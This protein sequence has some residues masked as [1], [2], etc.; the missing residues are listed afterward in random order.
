MWKKVVEIQTQ[1]HNRETCLLCLTA[2]PYNNDT[3]TGSTRKS[4]KARGGG[5]GVGGLGA[6][7]YMHESLKQV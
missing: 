6:W 7:Q 3:E 2:T 4:N 1:T 5:V